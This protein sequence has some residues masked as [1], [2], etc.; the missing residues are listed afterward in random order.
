MKGQLL[1][2]LK[3]F[4]LYVSFSFCKNSWYSNTLC[5]FFIVYFSLM[6]INGIVS[7]FEM[8]SSFFLVISILI[9]IE[10]IPHTLNILLLYMCKYL[11][12][13]PSQQNYFHNSQNFLS[14]FLNFF[15]YISF[16]LCPV[17]LAIHT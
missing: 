5:L 17:V 2:A 8:H 13:F 14:Y 10:M 1:Q 16:I 12:Y 7:N 4:Y 9:I 15:L 11:M 6:K 3:R